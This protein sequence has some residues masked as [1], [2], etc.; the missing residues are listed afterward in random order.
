MGQAILRQSNQARSIRFTAT[1]TLASGDIF[2]LVDGRAAV[3]GGLK[4][5]A[6]GDVFDAIV[7]GEADI[8]SASATTFS[9]GDVAVWDDS[10]NAAIANGAAAIVPGDIVL[11]RV[12]K[13]KVSGELTVRVELNEGVAP[14]VITAT[15]GITLTAKDCAPGRGVVVHNAGAGGAVAVNLPAA[16]PGLEVVGLVQA[17]Q[18]LRLNPDG[19]ETI[20]LPST[21]VAGAAGKYLTANAAGESVVLKCF[22]AG[23]WCCLGYTGTWTAEA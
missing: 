20:S 7:S 8:A 9:V 10:A 22:V 19:T 16:T 15:D 2:Q 17:A 12:V 11:G 3:V 6:S 21:G 23:S 5:V 4:A 13:A 14:L 1:G 18:E